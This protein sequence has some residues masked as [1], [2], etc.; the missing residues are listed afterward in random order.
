[1]GKANT[2]I[3]KRT[4]TM[5][6]SWCRVRDARGRPDSED[7]DS[8][9]SSQ[10]A[11]QRDGCGASG[12][13]TGDS[14]PPTGGGSTQDEGEE[15]DLAATGEAVPDVVC[16]HVAV[17]ADHSPQ[18]L[19]APSAAGMVAAPGDSSISPMAEQLWALPVQASGG[20]GGRE[21]GS[22]CLSFDLPSLGLGGADGLAGHLLGGLCLEAEV[23]PSLAGLLGYAQFQHYPSTATAS[24]AAVPMAAPVAAAHKLHGVDHCGR[25]VE[26]GDIGAAHGG[27][28]SPPQV[29]SSGQ[30]WASK[31]GPDDAPE[32]PGLFDDD[33]PATATASVGPAALTAVSGRSGAAEKAGPCAGA[34]GGTA[35][36]GGNAEC[37]GDSG[38]G[39]EATRLASKER[40]SLFKGGAGLASITPKVCAKRRSRR[41][42]D[43]KSV[44]GSVQEKAGGVANSDESAAGANPPGKSAS[45][46]KKGSPP[47]P[48]RRQQVKPP[49]LVS[50][51]VEGDLFIYHLSGSPGSHNLTPASEAERVG[52]LEGSGTLGSTEALPPTA[53]EALPGGGVVDQDCGTAKA[54]SGG[55]A[56]RGARLRSTRLLAKLGSKANRYD[57]LGHS[58]PVAAATEGGAASF[59][60]GVAHH[61]GHGHGLRL[62]RGAAGT[63]IAAAVA[64]DTHCRRAD[65]A[66]GSVAAA[67]PPTKKGALA[68]LDP[69]LRKLL[70]AGR[71]PA[72][73]SSNSAQNDPIAAATARAGTSSATNSGTPS[74]RLSTP[75]S[76]PGSKGSSPAD[77][78]RLMHWRRVRERG[79]DTLCASSRGIGTPAVVEDALLLG[80][81]A[82]GQRACTAAH[83]ARR[84]HLGTAVDLPATAATSTLPARP[85]TGPTK[86][87][88]ASSRN[89]PG[90]VAGDMPPFD[91]SLFA[92]QSWVQPWVPSGSRVAGYVDWYGSP[93][94]ESCLGALLAAEERRGSVGGEAAVGQGGPGEAVAHW[95]TVRLEH[96][97]TELRELVGAEHQHDACMERSAL[98]TPSQP[99]LERCRALLDGLCGELQVT[100]SS[101]HRGV[102]SGGPP[103]GEGGDA[104][105]FSV[106]EVGALA[107]HAKEALA[108]HDATARLIAGLVE[109][110]RVLA[111]HGGSS[112]PGLGGSGVGSPEAEHLTSIDQALTQG[113]SAWAQ[114]FGYLAATAATSRASSAEQLSAHSP[115]R[116]G[117]AAAAVAAAARGPAIFV[118]CGRDAL[119]AA[120]GGAQHSSEA[121]S[122]ISAAGQC[123]S[124]VPPSLRTVP[125]MRGLNDALEAQ[126]SQ[127]SSTTGSFAGSLLPGRHSEERAARSGTRA[128]RS[129]LRNGGGVDAAAW[130]AGTAAASSPG[131]GGDAAA[132]TASSKVMGRSLG[133]GWKT[134][135]AH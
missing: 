110:D 123:L 125:L 22:M 120:R 87:M 106:H 99:W 74:T 42:D 83:G 82:G 90:L 122:L 36:G 8:E 94:H 17:A 111:S 96:T 84:D 4:G 133:T 38:D 19:Q 20:G 41:L 7:D 56:Q 46:P 92:P 75:K 131:S 47:R 25:S 29:I 68:P 27:A 86:T 71:T 2:T 14:M 66:L 77:V 58:S 59:G 116:S 15:H 62:S 23:P 132:C 34:T 67:S 39:A 65:G 30:E 44:R 76:P 91:T 5:P 26:S 13:D 32:A 88:T 115:Q 129:L 51:A 98:N 24:M 113:L 40:Q 102:G 101:W 81:A 118:W 69:G 70:G 49:P 119:E 37:G 104:A 35:S 105:H 72:S 109:R 107:E 79:W 89:A 95:L 55:G 127:A 53:D 10:G 31:I 3:V 6:A 48:K 100:R 64:S 57:S 121:E 73:S 117:Y 130:L 97:H 108:F 80:A 61:H 11:I 112:G 63:G 33:M 50:A 43:L 124:E 9:T 18:Q 16:G 78:A 135:L 12:A 28:M 52:S 45:C 114:R 128:L 1:M 60:G 103:R 134:V 93:L 126:R 54:A 21:S 85:M